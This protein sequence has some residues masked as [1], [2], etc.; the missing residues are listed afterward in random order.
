[1][2]ES[3]KTNSLPKAAG[4]LA[5]TANAIFLI[6]LNIFACAQPSGPLLA[7]V[8]FEVVF[9]AAMIGYRLWR[10]QTPSSKQAEA[11]LECLEQ[12]SHLLRTARTSFALAGIALSTIACLFLTIDL[13]A[14]LCANCGQQKTAIRLYQVVAPPLMLLDV[15]PAL[16]LEMLAGAYIQ[17]GKWDRAE[18]LEFTLVDIRQTIVGEKHALMAAIY[19][20][21]GDL[22]K[23]S[24]KLKQ[25]E[26]YYRKAIALSKEIHYRLGYGSPLTKLAVL[27]RDEQRFPEADVAFKE[28]LSIRQAIFGRKSLKA[29]E[30]MKEYSLLKLEQGQ[31]A[32]A[33]SLEKQAQEIMN[34][35]PRRSSDR[36]SS[37]APLVVLCLSFLIFSQRDRILILLAARVRKTDTAQKAA[38]V[39]ASTSGYD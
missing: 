18:Q 13:A 39:V 8:A 1:M 22:Y 17:A 38:V 7:A 23:R 14:L 3:M 35:S 27:L 37:L 32:A 6:Y 10:R 31:T 24:S 12:H 25:S 16:S 33:T 28:A 21:L 34:G 36:L 30:T 11:A 4:T 9:F 29:A 20:D 15:H 2:Q 26:A 19:A 5:L